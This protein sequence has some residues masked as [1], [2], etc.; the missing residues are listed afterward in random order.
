MV[1]TVSF[2]FST[3]IFPCFTLLYQRRRAGGFDCT[4]ERNTILQHT[5]YT[6]VRHAK[7]LVVQRTQYIDKSENGK[8]TLA[9]YRNACAQIDNAV[10]LL[11]KVII[12]NKQ[13]SQCM[14]ILQ[15]TTSH[16]V[17]ENNE[18]NNEIDKASEQTKK[19][20]TV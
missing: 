5:Q 13:P 11:F 7:T 4:M 10:L 8:K 12:K 20:A 3:S 18:M 15:Q 2:F 16:D 9:K 1:Y 19:E 14:N 6:I 17:N